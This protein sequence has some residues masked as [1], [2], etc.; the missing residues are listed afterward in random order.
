MNQEIEQT[1]FTVSLSLEAHTRAKQFQRHH[2]N[3]R[4]AKQ[5]YL[6]TLA[7]YAVHFYLECLEFEPDWAASDSGNPAQQALLE[8]ADLVVNGYGKLECRPVLP[9]SDQMEIP[10]ETWANRR[11][12][13][14][15]Q[16][17]ESLREATILGFVTQGRTESVPL[18]QL[19]PLDEL[20]P[21]LLQVNATEAAPFAI[22]ISQWL[23]DGINSGW[24]AIE[25][26]LGSL[27]QPVQPAFSFRGSEP[28]SPP[29]ES[30]IVKRSQ[31]LVLGTTGEQV[32]L[33]MGVLPISESE[34]EIWVQ[35]TPTD[36]Q[37]DL[38]ANLEV[39]VLDGE[40]VEVTLPQARSQEAIQ[41]QFVGELGEAFSL[42]LVLG[43]ITL[44]KTFVI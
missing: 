38:P 36:G 9:D 34:F 13:L 22:P 27:L 8:G 2:A 30:P 31:Q 37:T 17:S 41:S 6:N 1:T 43:S 7:I 11:A 10:A 21:H 5:V 28:L 44:T 40:G 4:K 33:L 32:S 29:V 12:Y 18:S 39:K 20:L 25:E 26:F 19:K 15:V 35:I 14:A 42:K 24:Q 3:P 16:L 23:Q